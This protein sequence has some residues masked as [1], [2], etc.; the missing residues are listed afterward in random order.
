MGKSHIEVWVL[1]KELLKFVK[2]D[3]AGSTKDYQDGFV[4]KIQES[5][6]RI[7]GSREM[8]ERF[9]LLDDFGPVTVMNSERIFWKKGIWI[10]F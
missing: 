9:M 2:A 4:K 5:M 7:K 3:L 6:A 1:R 10:Y 8:E